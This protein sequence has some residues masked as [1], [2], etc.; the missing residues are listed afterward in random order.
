MD[1]SYNRRRFL[2]TT[3]LSGLGLSLAGQ[4]PGLAAPAPGKRVGIIG[5]DT[6]HSTAFTKV[7]NAAD[8]SGELLG[9][10]VVAA[11]PYGSR[12]IETSTKRIPGYIEEV[13]KLDVEIVNSIQ[14][15]LK[16]VD[17][18]LLETNDGRLHLEQATEVLKAG[19]R[20]F[21]DKPIAASL[22]DT[23]KIF[24][25]SKKYK[26]PLFSA[27]SLRYIKG[28]EGLDKSKVVGADTYSPAVL[29]KTHPDFF[30]Y[31]VHGVETLFTVMGRGCQSVVRVHNEGT[32]IVVG[33]WADGRVGTFRGTRTGKHNY[34]GTVY[35]QD[36]NTTL[37]P[38]NGYQ[39]LLLE[40]IKYF[41]TG[42]VP[43]APEET[44]EI[45]AFM[46][47]ADESKRRGGAAVTLA[48]V[49]E[50]ARKA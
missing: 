27:S 38:Y 49:L 4:L 16:K 37:G 20:V 3:A 30:W 45:F 21:I 36:G 11:Y 12:D 19:K 23:L 39:P 13:K 15:L 18:V 31:G 32:D 1:T 25:A 46:E 5:L 33:T 29:E 50:K 10:K 28:V 35:T 6:S 24:E 8:A 2:K 7:L 9:Y 44:I 43:V 14:D 22:S 41:E 17:V 47:A 34:G 42:Q 26:V 48:S 40:I